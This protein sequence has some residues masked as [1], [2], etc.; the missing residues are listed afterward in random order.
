MF[1]QL[2]FIH[3]FRPFLKYKQNTTPL[4]SNVSPRKI[5]THAASMISKLIRLYKRTHGLRQICNI[6][7]YISHS[8][9]T[10]HLLNL[11]DKNASRD[12]I[13]GLKHVE[14]IGESWLCARRT[15][16]ILHLVSKRWSIEVPD[17]ADKTFMRAE[18]KYG[19]L[20]DYESSP[21]PENQMP[22]PTPMQPLPSPVATTNAKTAHDVNHSTGVHGVPANGFFP[23]TTPITSPMITPDAP[24]FDGAL[25]MQPPPAAEFGNKS[26][27]HSY[28]MPQGRQQQP[29]RPQMRD[30]WNQGRKSSAPQTTSPTM[31][32][33]GVEGLIQDQEWWLRDSNQM[34]A[35]WTGMEHEA[36]MRGNA[37]FDVGTGNS[38]FGNGTYGMN[39]N[40]NGNGNGNMDFT[41]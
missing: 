28:V 27:Q 11:P 7:V 13:H 24:S 40:R 32:F 25:S 18:A 22:P 6:V 5:L 30:A 38:G 10:I 39:G 16:G 9:C 17:E 41:R 15:L 3:L 33:G 37:G 8:A 34:F 31:L 35:N 20:K 29:Q 14:E 1:F 36:M 4:P 12:I 21:K 23:S 19:A 2:L 26:R